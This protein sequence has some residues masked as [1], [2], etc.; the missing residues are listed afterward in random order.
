MTRSKTWLGFGLVATLVGAFVGC[1]KPDERKPST[2]NDNAPNA[3]AFDP[4]SASLATGA[5]AKAA[6]PVTASAAACLACENNST[7]CQEFL[8][9]TSVA[10]QA[11]KGSPA[12]G[13]PKSAL[14]SE[15]LDCVR[16]SGCAT[17]NGI[18]KCYCGSADVQACQS[19]HA[20]GACKAE[21]ERGL[22]ATSFMDI[23]RHLKN[24]EFGGGLA[25]ARIDCDQQACRAAC[26]L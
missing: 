22:E 17:S 13:T 26:G 21:L 16:K 15:V 9:C 12:A 23:A 6:A 14:C 2:A 10:G 19:G 4:Q 11:A 8:D 18:I 25:M 20:N 3:A 24:K 5:S 7:A 1:S